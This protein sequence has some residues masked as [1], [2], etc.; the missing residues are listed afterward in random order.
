MT[1]PAL[2]VGHAG[3]HHLGGGDVVHLGHGVTQLQ[4]LELERICFLL[5]HQFH[6]HLPHPLNLRL[7]KL[8]NVEGHIVEQG[9]GVGQQA[10]VRVGP[11]LV[12]HVGKLQDPPSSVHT[13]QHVATVPEGG[14]DVGH[15]LL[16][17]RA[18][19]LLLACV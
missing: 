8:Y 1:E 9:Q 11:E 10:A 14:L 16:V 5:S 4:V 12:H 6:Q 18:L 15:E 7:A 17:P 13:D 3:E 19:S 2:H